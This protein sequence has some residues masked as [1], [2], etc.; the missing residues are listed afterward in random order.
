MDQDTLVTL[1][2]ALCC[3]IALGTAATALDSAVSTEPGDVINID[4]ESVPISA[5]DAEQLRERYEQSAEDGGDEPVERAE[6]S[7]DRESDSESA[8]D[9][10][11]SDAASDSADSSSDDSQSADSAESDS[12]ESQPDRSWLD[13]LLALLEALLGVLLRVFAILLLVAAAIVAYGYSDR[14]PFARDDPEPS[15]EETDANF[16]PEPPS[17]EV[18]RAWYA[19][20]TS[21]DLPA[22]REKTPHQY[23]AEAID[24][25]ADPEAVSVLTNTFEEVRY[26]NRPATEDRID[27]AQRGLERIRSA[28]GSTASSDGTRAQES[29]TAHAPESDRNHT[30]KSRS[31]NGANPSDPNENRGDQR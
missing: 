29:G 4:Y 3:I 19:M 30:P 25:G 1:T 20:I 11:R 14:L 17:N 8:S 2:L 26:G 7:G 22:R 28:A 18:I 31:P 21:L 16:D 13:R 5:E 6:Q 15:N 24:E 23:S 27:R 9:S 12:P 10:D